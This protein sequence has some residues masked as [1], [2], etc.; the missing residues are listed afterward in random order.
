MATRSPRVLPRR[1][2]LEGG[3]AG[4]ALLLSR[5]VVGC[6]KDIVV[7]ATEMGDDAGL[8]AGSDELPYRAIARPRLVS[9]IAAI[10]PLGEPD[11]NGVRLPAGFTAR[12]VGRSSKPV[13]E[14]KS[15]AWH[16]AP[17]GGATFPTE[18][19]GWIYVSNSELPFAGGV[20]ALRFDAAGNLVDAYPILEGTNVNCAGGP[21]PWNTW[22]SCEEVYRGQVYECDPWGE[23][24]A[25]VRPALGTFKHEAA[26]VDP[27]AHRVYLTEDE[28]DGCLYRFVPDALTSHGFAKLSSGKLEVAAVAGD[29][30]VTWHAL[31]DPLF[32]GDVPTRA[33]V[34]AATRFDGGEGI[35]W[36]DGVVYFTTKGDDRV[37]A[38]DTRTE[39]I[40]VLYDAATSP[41]PILTGVDNVTVSASG[42]VLVAEDGGDMQ[43]VAILPTGELKALVQLVDYAESEITGPAFDPS[44]TRLYFSSQRGPKG[45]TTFEI[46]GPFHAPA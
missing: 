40:S 22:L 42:D 7:A 8:D 6:S 39:R 41:N 19:G 4:L 15:F 38:Y 29:G 20:G 26:A 45:G 11:A 35:W 25:I 3:L 32:E 34:A 33:Q 23:H 44:G 27:I 24:A 9:T 37:R 2:I 13:L 10:G 14:G 17:D 36:H 46:T 21:T 16:S 28:P 1:A 31:P 30:A 12:I 18:D 43:V 5:S